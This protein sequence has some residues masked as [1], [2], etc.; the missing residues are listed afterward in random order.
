MDMTEQLNTNNKRKPDEREKYNPVWTFTF[1]L[2]NIFLVEVLF[3]EKNGS[4]QNIRCECLQTFYEFFIEF[5]V[6]YN[7]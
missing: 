5:I 4:N 7:L 2:Y 6:S 1:F 3:Y